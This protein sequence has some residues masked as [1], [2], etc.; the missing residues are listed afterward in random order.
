MMQ[1]KNT[2]SVVSITGLIVL[3]LLSSVGVCSKET[4]L[5][6]TTLA[7][8]EYTP[9]SHD[10]GNVLQGTTDNT[11]FEIWRGGGYCSITYTLNWN[12]EWIDVFPTS[13]TSNG[14]HDPITVSIDTTGLE[15]GEYYGEVHIQSNA[16]SGVFAVTVH[17]VESL[18]PKVSYAPENHHF[19]NKVAGETDTTT[20]DIWNC[21]DGELLY[22]FEWSC[23]WIAIT[24]ENG[25]C[26]NEHDMIQVDL[27]TTGLELGLHTC[28]IAIHS[29]G[30]TGNFTVWVMIVE[31]ET[32][33]LSYDP[34]AHDFLEKAEGETD[35]TIFDIWNAQGGELLYSFNWDADWVDVVPTS[36]NSIGEHDKITVSIDTT[37]MNIG[38]Y[39]TDIVIYSNAGTELFTVSVTIISSEKLEIESI[40]GGLGISTLIKNKG[41]KDAVNV[42]VSVSIDGGLIIFPK[43][44]HRTVSISAG[45]SKELNAHVFGFGLGIL[46]EQPL[47]TVTINSPHTDPVSKSISARIAAF[48]VFI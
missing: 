5:S 43:E 36:G 8:L 26:H 1:V 14:E 47:V 27:D 45:E 33:Y 6:D 9:K 48:F 3:T 4:T 28:T 31:N 39:S 20:F 41:D 15:Y 18:E 10:F 11:V 2:W 24:P 44:T 12:E 37:A 17:V 13:G 23:S 30:G 21:G 42:E 38:N 32:P 29:N 25:S 46:G 7:T 19:Y 35:S 34:T 22:S 40:C 16:G